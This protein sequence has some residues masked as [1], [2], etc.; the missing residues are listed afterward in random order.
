MKK[1]GSR[2]DYRLYLPCN[3]VTLSPDQGG[4]EH[5]T[6]LGSNKS[7]GL[8]LGPQNSFVESPPP[9]FLISHPPPPARIGEARLRVG[10]S[11]ITLP[12]PPV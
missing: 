2:A 11:G 5:S 3:K 4:S 7:R 9:L 6:D 8:S 1:V 12:T 10:L